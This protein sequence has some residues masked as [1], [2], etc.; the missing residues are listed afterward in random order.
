GVLS[1]FSQIQPKLIFSVNAVVYNGK[2]HNHFDKLKCVVDEL[3]NIEKV[4]IVPFVGK[5][6]DIQMPDIPNSV[7][8]SEFLKSGCQNDGS[9]PALTFEQLPFNHPLYIMYSS[10]TTGEPKCM[11]HSAGVSIMVTSIQSPPLYHVFIRYY[12]R[13]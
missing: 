7:L 6:E 11:V 9:Y 12:R 8:L 13:A 3:T 10:G 5:E 1:R 2:T 4:V